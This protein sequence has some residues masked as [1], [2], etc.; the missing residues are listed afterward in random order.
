MQSTSTP[1][2][3][4][5]NHS[6]T[7]IA[8]GYLHTCALTPEGRAYCWGA[9][10]VEPEG[11]KGLLARLRAASMCS[12]AT[13]PNAAGGLTASPPVLACAGRNT[14]GQLGDGTTDWQ[15]TPV[16]VATDL[17]FVDIAAGR[18]HT[19]GLLANSSYAC[20]G[21]FCNDA[22][23]PMQDSTT[24]MA[25]SFLWHFLTVMYCNKI[26]RVSLLLSYDHS[27]VQMPMANWEMDPW[28]TA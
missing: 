23:A 19:C 13:A 10:S 7:H 1:V 14:N 26:Q 27:Q 12:T 25:F 28:R 17:V 22:H 9:A 2:E 16:S 21:E 15:T 11:R 5:G 20:W 18:D 4:S 3:V 24:L 6:F 8:A